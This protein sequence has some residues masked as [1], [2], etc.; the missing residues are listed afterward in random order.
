MAITSNHV[1]GFV[2][3]LGSATALFYLYRTNQ[4]QVDEWLRTQ[5][6]QLPPLAYDDPSSWSLEQLVR[7]KER[8]EDLIAEREMGAA[9]AQVGAAAG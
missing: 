7:E 4:A 5:G 9:D 1:T 3:G 6:I 8:L 2:F